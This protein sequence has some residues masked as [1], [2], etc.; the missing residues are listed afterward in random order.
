MDPGS[1]A[2]LEKQLWAR[3]ESSPG[4]SD[5][6]L[7]TRS[8][9]GSRKCRALAYRSPIS[10]RVGPHVLAGREEGSLGGDGGDG[11]GLVVSDGATDENW[12]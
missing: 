5:P 7:H 3:R 8:P 10:C 9:A 2:K 12:G 4:M 11:S 6:I 1:A